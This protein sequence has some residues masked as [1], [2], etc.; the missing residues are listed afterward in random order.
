M[1][2]HVPVVTNLSADGTR[3]PGGYAVQVGGNITFTCTHNGSFG[4]SL[5][6]EFDIANRTATKFPITAVSLRGEPGFSTSA[7][8][9]TANPASITIYN[10]QLANNG[11]TVKCQL[12][13]EGSPAVIRVEGIIIIT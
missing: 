3:V 13:T 2:I 7:T 10:L 12:E 8:E 9:N 11:S 1:Q 5:F 6:W 4:R